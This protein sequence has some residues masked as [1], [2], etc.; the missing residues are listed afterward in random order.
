MELDWT[1]MELERTC[2]TSEM[3]LQLLAIDEEMLVLSQW[4]ECRLLSMPV[5]DS[6]LSTMNEWLGDDAD[7]VIVIRWCDG[8]GHR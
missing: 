2:K 7:I 5:D 8:T 1:C 6:L 4:M 3:E